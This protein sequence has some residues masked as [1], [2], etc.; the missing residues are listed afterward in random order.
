MY[1]NAVRIAS[2]FLFVENEKTTLHNH[3]L[4]F[5][6]EREIPPSVE[7]EISPKGRNEK[8][9]VEVTE[10]KTWISDNGKEDVSFRGQTQSQAR[11]L[12]VPDS[13]FPVCLVYW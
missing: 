7:R 8:G 4:S 3:G 9:R 13:V 6:A 11:L 5:R 12:L 2:F 10:G 1:G